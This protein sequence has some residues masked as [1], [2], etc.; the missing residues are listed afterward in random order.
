MAQNG[1][2]K[3]SAGI[4]SIAFKL[5]VSIG[6]AFTFACSILLF[7]AIRNS[8]G[9]MTEAYKKYTM[10]VA[11][12]AATAVDVLCREGTGDDSHGAAV[13]EEMISLLKSDAEGNRQVLYDFYGPVLGDIELTGIDGSYA[14]MV[15]ADGTTLYHPSGERIGNPVENEAVKGLTARLAS[16]EKPS[17]IGAGSVVYEFKGS[18]KFAGYAFTEG[19]NIV[20]VTGDY[21]L[22]M[23]PVK[24]MRN[25]MIGASAGLLLT[26]LIVFFF[27]ITL[28]LKPIGTLIE[29]ID[30]TASFNL[31]HNPKSGALLKRKDEFGLISASIGN[32]RAS[33][34]EIVDDIGS[35]AEE[36][37]AN[38]TE[39]DETAEVVNSMCTDNSATTQEMAASM[40]E[41]ANSADHMNTD[42]A[43]IRNALHQIEMQTND[44]FTVS[45]EI[46]ERAT[47]LRD[48]TDK[49]SDTTGGI[50]ADVK[51]RSARAIEDSKVVERINELTGA[52]MAISSQTSLLALNASIEA[53]R[54]GEAGRGFA[55]VATEIGN[56]A[57]QT[58][59]SVGDIN[60]IVAEVNVAV[61]QMQS[62]LEEMGDFLEN[63]VL[64][65]FDSIKDV[66]FRYQDDADIFKD[67]MS[68]IK[69]SVDELTETMAGM[70]DLVAS[71]SG[72]VGE[73]AE[74]VSDIAGKTTDIVQGMSDTGIKVG[75]CREYVGKLRE[76]ISRF[77]L[78]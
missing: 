57:D 48:T 30:A 39:L 63:T 58:S 68:S 55:V 77:E 19:G 40:Q 12:S 38:V 62:C 23:K 14:Y 26:F 56:L 78:D 13:E 20:V 43:N 24:T 49:S 59:R 54:A 36:I 22:V 41:C 45:D 17:S 69:N 60:G 51:A 10:N 5:V 73:S 64:K 61:S 32:M 4:H 50:F 27:I 15:S 53:A 33:L 44:G 16:G 66:G 52:I 8:E 31:R 2:A 76:V 67:C 71:I 70:A 6:L 28:I 29:I 9:C 7:I 21:D 74:G 47:Q 37:D 11:Q 25:R 3:K 34:R 18:D 72:A 46:M 42:I 35:A 65:N 1:K 75:Q